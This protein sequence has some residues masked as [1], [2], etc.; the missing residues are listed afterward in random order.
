MATQGP[1]VA[2]DIAA[3]AAHLLDARELAPRARLAAQAVADLLPGTAVNIYML[4]EQE[5]ERVWIP[6]A[7]VG[8]VAVAELFVPLDQGALGTLG[9]APEVVALSGTE[10]VR[11]EYAHLHVRRTIQ[12]LAYVPL[13]TRGDLLGA[14]EIISFDGELEQATLS[15]LRPVADLIASALDNAR[16]YEQERHSTLSSITRLTQLYDIEKVLSST[17]ELDELLPLIGSKFK[18]LLECQ[19]INVWL[20]EGNESVTL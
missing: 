3:L 2:I 13:N 4:G 19:A 10:L 17:L 16:E 18:E 1:I 9:N 6:Q 8:D 7:S 11:E 14:V 12:S 20:L 15:A 5:G